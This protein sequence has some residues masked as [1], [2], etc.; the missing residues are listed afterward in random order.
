MTKTA[1]K[2]YRIENP[3]DMDG[4]WY[5]KNGIAR[6]KIHLLCPDGISK[7]LPM[8][9]NVKLHRKD[10]LIWNSAG[11]SVENMRHWFTDT[12]AKSLYNNGFRLFEFITTLYNELEHEILFCRDG[13]VMQREIPLETILKL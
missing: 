5:T 6:K 1:R 10:G 8:P 12:D 11:K 2:V 3:I 13:V 7:D 9:L 4:M